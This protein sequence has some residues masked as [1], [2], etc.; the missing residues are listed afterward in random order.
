[1]EVVK[2]VED[3]GGEGFADLG[4]WEGVLLNEG[5]GVTELQETQG[6]AGAGGAGSENSDIVGGVGGVQVFQRGVKRWS[7]S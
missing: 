7:R 4:A 1:M 6:G 3:A 2:E 5:D